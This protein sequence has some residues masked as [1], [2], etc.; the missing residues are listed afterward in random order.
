M[1][2]P[3]DPAYYCTVDEIFVPEAQLVDDK[4]PTC[5]SKV[6]RLKENLAALGGGRVVDQQILELAAAD[7]DGDGRDEVLA[8]LERARVPPEA[9][10]PSRSSSATVST[11]IRAP[12]CRT[13]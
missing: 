9:L 13:R 12:H 1:E 10:S 4:C 11:V 7:V 2:E 5:G 3:F 6:E 8:A